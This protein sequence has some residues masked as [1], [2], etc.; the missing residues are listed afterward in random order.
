MQYYKA[1]ESIPQQDRTDWTVYDRITNVQL[2][3]FNGLSI[4]DCGLDMSISSVIARL[5]E[6]KGILNV[7]QNPDNPYFWGDL[8]DV[9]EW[10]QFGDLHS[11]LGMIYATEKQGELLKNLDKILELYTGDNVDREGILGNGLRVWMKIIDR[12]IKDPNGTRFVKGNHDLAAFMFISGWLQN[13]DFQKELFEKDLLNYY[14]YG[15][16][17][18]KGDRADNI[19][20]KTFVF[21]A[22][23]YYISQGENFENIE[24]FMLQLAS[25]LKKVPYS[26]TI[27][28]KTLFMHANPSENMIAASRRE[29]EADK[30]IEEYLKTQ[31]DRLATIWR[32]RAGADAVKEA[33]LKH[34]GQ[35]FKQ[36][37]NPEF[38]RVIVKIAEIYLAC[39]QDSVDPAAKLEETR[40]SIIDGVDGDFGKAVERSIWTAAKKCADDAIKSGT[41]PDVESGLINAAE[42][43]IATNLNISE[44]TWEDVKEALGGRSDAFEDMDGGEAME[45]TD[46]DVEVFL[47]HFN[48]EELENGHDPVS[49]LNFATTIES[50]YHGKVGDGVGSG[51]GEALVVKHTID[52]DGASKRTSYVLDA[53]DLGALRRDVNSIR[54]ESIKLGKAELENVARN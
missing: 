33:L 9:K 5:E 7:M 39:G 40:G 54:Y 31:E 10:V 38:E 14:K 3:I 48:L 1:I 47:R 42:D 30:P 43:Y 20:E 23:D 27:N 25:F 45:L 32:R 11:S 52:Q 46:H 44:M 29:G 36:N 21:D 17:K 51:Y 4:S 35:T 16:M 49:I 13:N 8:R 6:G 24:K 26:G 50:S 19:S 18:P 53:S 28:G 12:F 37:F 22:F 15:R 2:H 41:S 34:F